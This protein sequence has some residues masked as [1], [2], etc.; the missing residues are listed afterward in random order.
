MLPLLK[1][2]CI[3]N[4]IGPYGL[5][6]VGPPATL[7]RVEGDARRSSVDAVALGSVQRD[8]GL[9]ARWAGFARQEHELITLDLEVRHGFLS[10]ALCTCLKYQTSG[11]C[12]FIL[13]NL[14][15]NLILID[16]SEHK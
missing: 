11:I 16:I 13:P 15:Q 10:C 3:G 2:R 5:I 8:R 9:V 7:A 4:E 12:K 6:S 14:A 1:R